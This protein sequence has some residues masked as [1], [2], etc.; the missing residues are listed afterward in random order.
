M[1]NLNHI[2]VFAPAGLDPAGALARAARLVAPGGIV[3]VVDVLPDLPTLA[4]AVLPPAI[5]TTHL[6]DRERELTATA[7]GTP[8][9]ATVRIRV[10]AGHPAVRLSQ[11]VADERVDLV[12]RVSAGVA[13]DA[14]LDPVDLK[15]LRKCPCP[16]WIVAPGSPHA[17]RT[18]LAAVDVSAPE[19]DP[20]FQSSIIRS[21]GGAAARDGADLHVVHVWQVAAEHLLRRHLPGGQVEA[22]VRDTRRSA[23]SAVAQLLHT[24]EESDATVHVLR[25]E[26]PAAIARTAQQIE[27]DLIVIGTVAR[28]GLRGVIMGNTAELVLRSVECEVLVLKPEGFVS[29]LVVP[30]PLGVRS[31]E[32][33]F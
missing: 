14:S 6:R 7:A 5:N 21:A 23:E 18:V 3:T 15:L 16:V 13:A 19:A 27:A 1:R 11:F 10:M 8:G 33:V 25:G 9:Q 32:G 26:P 22:I 31:T 20:G 24:A 30:T 28:T 2:A 4:R 17:L 29:P 12:L